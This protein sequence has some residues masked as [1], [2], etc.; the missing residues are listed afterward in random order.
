[1]ALFAFSSAA[2]AREAVD[3]RVLGALRPIDALTGVQIAAPL[4][5]SAPGVRLTRNRSG[6]YVLLAAP[7]LEVHTTAFASPPPSPANGS[8]A[9]EVTVADPAGRFLT[10]RAT[11][12]LPRDPSPAAVTQPDSLFAL[13]DVAM[14]PAP[15]ARTAAGWAVIRAT[16]TGTSGGSPPRPLAGALIRV[17]RASDAARLAAGLSDARGEAL[18]AVPGIPITTWDAGPGPVLATET[19]V[20]L[21][22]IFDPAAPAIPDPDDLEA[23]RATLP[24]S[25][26]PAKLAAGREIVAALV[27][28]LP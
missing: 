3:R 19:D 5:V 1:M 28:A 15:A 18:V 20:T 10:R 4:V 11:V 17:V 9:I 13:V 16:V 24:S 22:T 6:R 12:R 21:E 2:G 27:V 25:A 8:V 26:V 7:G 14:Y 23:R